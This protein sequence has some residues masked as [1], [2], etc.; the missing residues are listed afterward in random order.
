M[1]EKKHRR[2][3]KGTQKTCLVPL[4]DESVL[5]VLKKKGGN[6]ARKKGKERYRNYLAYQS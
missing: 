4:P 3:R 6:S 5:L 1:P 2:G